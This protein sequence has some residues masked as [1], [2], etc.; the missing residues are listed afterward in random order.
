VVE[1]LGKVGNGKLR[2]TAE[3]TGAFPAVCVA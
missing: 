2:R 1:L 3:H